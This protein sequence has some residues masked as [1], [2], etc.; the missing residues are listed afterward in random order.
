[1]GLVVGATVGRALQ[2]LELDLAAVRGV[3]LAPGLG[4]QG[5]TAADLRA[6]FGAAYAQ[7]LGTSS[8]D[9]LSAGPAVTSLRDAARRTLDPL[10]PG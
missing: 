10:L 6:T 5:A 3:I 1:V 8:R 7:V 9:I 2:D 4:A